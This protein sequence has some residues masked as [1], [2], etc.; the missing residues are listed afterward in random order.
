VPRLLRC[1]FRDVAR[2]LAIPILVGC[3]LRVL[4][5]EQTHGAVRGIRLS[6]ELDFTSSKAAITM[7]QVFM[8]SF[9]RLFA[10]LLL[11]CF[12]SSSLFAQ[13]TAAQQA[14][15]Q[16]PTF[17]TTVRRVIVDVVVRDSNNKPVH[18]LTPQNFIVAEDGRPQDILTFDVHDLD[19]PSI[20]I[21]ANAPHSPTNNFVNIPPAPE[22]GPLYVILYD[23]VNMEQADQIDARRQILKFIATKPA[24]T[25]FAIFVRSFDLTLVQGFTA[26]K[27][28]LYAVL[29]PATPAPHVPRVF[30]M[31]RNYGYGDPVS[32]MSVLTQVTE[33][34]DGIPGHK[35][36]I[37]LAGTFPLALV[38]RKEDPREYV[39]Q[40]H[41][42]INLLTRAEVAV[43]PINVGGVPVNPPGALTGS[44]VHGGSTNGS[45]PA[46]GGSGANGMTAPDASG[47]LASIRAQGSGDSVLTDYYVQSA[48]AESTG[49]RA[50]YST[51]DVTAALAD[52]TDIGGNYYTLAYS[53]ANAKDDGSRRT[54]QLRVKHPGYHLDYRRF[55]FTTAYSNP[56][57]LE[58]VSDSKSAA[59]STPDNGI[60]QRNMKHGA[61]MVHELL[62]SAHIRAD[63]AA[64]PATPEQMA[65][66]AGQPG[67]RDSRRGSKAGKLL[68]PVN[69][70]TYLIDYRVTDNALKSLIPRDGKQSSFE[71]AAAAFDVD[72][73]MLNGVL[74]EAVV[75]SGDQSK[76]AIFRIRQQ[77][78][79]PLDA[80]WIRIGVQD[81]LTNRIG[82]LEVQL[83][84]LPEPTSV[85]S[86]Q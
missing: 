5:Q 66:L 57:E 56:S 27:D 3:H 52:A 59:P 20:A 12:C 49:G 40:I 39:D 7:G 9:C 76:T 34:M 64:T 45:A 72:G 55:Y 48:L 58:N 69:L 8:M 46:D 23:M 25:R 75:S 60:L 83:P 70:Q 68:A 2:C 35:N 85:I 33:F 38:P 11:S 65:K 26:D 86:A 53:P 54:I 16:I 73:R 6:C 80:T 21:P 32:M 22:H 41:A 50:F 79:V 19:T 4:P 61:S 44:R 67:D 13:S 17:R 31:Q 10:V 77:L 74:N 47:I 42:E 30:M 1:L 62:F 51:N 28:R 71:F 81:K 63:G 36:L 37:W 82:T 18:G 14:A 43:Y 84:L 78:D 15:N 29:D 24:G